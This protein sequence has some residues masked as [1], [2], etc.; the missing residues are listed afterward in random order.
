MDLA[1]LAGWLGEL[2]ETDCDLLGIAKAMNLRAHAELRGWGLGVR[3]E[4]N[5]R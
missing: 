5:L 2:T 1:I 3:S 4:V